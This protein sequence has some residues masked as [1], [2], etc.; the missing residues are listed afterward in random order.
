M[1]ISKHLIQERLHTMNYRHYF[2]VFWQQGLKILGDRVALFRYNP[3][4]EW[5]ETCVRSF[6]NRYAPSEGALSRPVSACRTGGYF[7]LRNMPIGALR[8]I[9]ALCIR[10]ISVPYTDHRA[11]LGE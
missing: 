6:E 3:T 10:A 5:R 2:A 4:G 11:K 9:G 8:D 1:I 7:S